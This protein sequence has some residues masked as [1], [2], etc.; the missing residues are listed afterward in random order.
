MVTREEI[1]KAAG[2]MPDTYVVNLDDHFDL[3][4]DQL[5]SENTRNMNDLIDAGSNMP[6][7]TELTNAVNAVW[8]LAAQRQCQVEPG[9]DKYVDPLEH[10]YMYTR[11]NTEITPYYYFMS[12]T[13]TKCIVDDIVRT[14]IQEAQN[15]KARYILLHAS[16]KYECCLRSIR[17]VIYDMLAFITRN[18]LCDKATQEFN[19]S[20]AK[21]DRED[22]KEDAID[23]SFIMA[24]IRTHFPRTADQEIVINWAIGMIDLLNP[25][26]HQ[27]IKKGPSNQSS[28]ISSAVDDILS[29]GKRYRELTPE[30]L[31]VMLD[32]Y[33]DEH[34]IGFLRNVKSEHPNVYHFKLA[35]HTC[36]IIDPD[37][38]GLPNGVWLMNF[39]KFLKKTETVIYYDNIDELFLYAKMISDWL[40]RHPIGFVHN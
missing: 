21:F 40:V 23:E 19:M 39:K 7:H 20:I 5:A 4:I 35:S 13:D 10:K 29:Y 38:S 34:V 2:S 14:I 1:L 24:L 16:E 32:E 15:Q 37:I 31:S 3:V 8:E 25:L 9:Y 17:A 30:K 36:G 33:D 6:I 27:L 28:L 18:E 11:I 22:Y 26:C 12:D